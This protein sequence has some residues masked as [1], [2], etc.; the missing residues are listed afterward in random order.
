M[1]LKP[2][3]GFHPELLAALGDQVDLRAK[4]LIDE[5]PE[6]LEGSRDS[7]RPQVIV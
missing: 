1:V 2:L 3:Q 7:R 6:Y 4:P 5:S